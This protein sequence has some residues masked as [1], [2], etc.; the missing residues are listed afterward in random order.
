MEFPWQIDEVDEEKLATG[1][2]IKTPEIF[3]LSMYKLFP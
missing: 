2:G 1:G 3:M